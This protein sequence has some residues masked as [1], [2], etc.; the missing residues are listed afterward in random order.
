M[1]RW[2]SAD[3]RHAEMKAAASPATTRM[4]RAKHIIIVNVIDD[5]WPTRDIVISADD[6][7]RGRATATAVNRHRRR[8]STS[9]VAR[10]RR[11]N[12]APFNRYLLPSLGVGLRERCSSKARPPLR[13]WFSP[14][15]LHRDIIFA[16]S[17]G[18]HTPSYDRQAM[19]YLSSRKSQ[20]DACSKPMICR[21]GRVA[22]AL[23]AASACMPNRS[24]SMAS[25]AHMW[26]HQSARSNSAIDATAS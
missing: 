9:R 6:T 21:G 13:P 8:L 10:P 18:A 19:I 22:D 23:V 2:L 24:S 16:R 15:R 3:A 12:L 17:I 5:D 1:R 4:L 25:V 7:Y 11:L 26:H 14:V 20:G